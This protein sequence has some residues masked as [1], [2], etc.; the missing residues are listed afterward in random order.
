[1][2]IETHGVSVAEVKAALPMDTRPITDASQPI[3]NPKL[4]AW[5]EEGAAQ[6]N[7]MLESKGVDVS[8]LS[9]FENAY[10][11]VR[12][13]IKTYVAMR[14]IEAQGDVGPLYEGMRRDWEAALKAIKLMTFNTLG[15]AAPASAVL[16]TNVPVGRS[17]RRWRD[18]GW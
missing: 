18:G 8:G 14:T 7:T 12:R 1:M 4:T 6:L 3:N 9:Q 5:I 11:V 2:A 16:H 15:N 10:S 17:R 13:A